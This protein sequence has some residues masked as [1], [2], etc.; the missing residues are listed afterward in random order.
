MNYNKEVITVVIIYPRFRYP[1][2]V[3][4]PWDKKKKTKI[5]NFYQKQE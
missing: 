2:P 5:H 3:A 4:N 1:L